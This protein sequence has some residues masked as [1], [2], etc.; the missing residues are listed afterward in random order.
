LVLEMICCCNSAGKVRSVGPAM[1][2]ELP[3]LIEEVRRRWLSWESAVSSLNT[4]AV[5]S[6]RLD[7]KLAS[8]NYVDSS[9]ESSDS[10][11]Y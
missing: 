10:Y 7:Q 5:H 11:I 4:E 1:L 9:E 2:I 6:I 8:V 3:M